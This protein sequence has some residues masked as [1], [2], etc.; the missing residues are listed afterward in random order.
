MPRMTAWAI[1]LEKPVPYA[2]GVKLQNMLVNARIAGEIPDTVLFL[3]HTSVITLGARAQD[4]HVL[5]SAEELQRRRIELHPSTRGGD[6]T[7][8]G[9][10]QL[11]MYP[12]I[13]LGEQEADAHGYLHNLEEI[14]IRTAADAGVRA[15]RR[16]GMTGAWTDQ[17]KLAAI[18]IRLKRW[19]TFHGMS[20][21]VNPD[22]SGFAAII[23]CGLQGEAIASFKT[24]LGAAC[25]DMAE[26]R[27]NMMRHF[28][29]VCRR[30][31][32]SPPGTSLDAIMA[33]CL[34]Q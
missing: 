14:A 30:K 28:S 27:A 1:L 11:V 20:F 29:E 7:W 4:T 26:V 33:Q 3:E 16:S 31:L 23:P 15:Y 12:I 34:V 24:L 19:V 6:V 10:G 21:N 17:G 9:P 13:R 22:L 18:G 25:P 2:E 8:H 5:L 32:Q